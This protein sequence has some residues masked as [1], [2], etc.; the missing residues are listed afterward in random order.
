M[1]MH[2][3]LTLTVYALIALVLIG[4]FVYMFLYTRGLRPKRDTLNQKGRLPVTREEGI[5][6]STLK[7]EHTGRTGTIT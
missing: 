7:K 1:H 4:V 2:P 6:V 5:A 3:T